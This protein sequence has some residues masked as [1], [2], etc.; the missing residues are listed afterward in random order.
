MICIGHSCPKSNFLLK[1]WGMGCSRSP[2]E[3]GKAERICRLPAEGLRR[4]RIF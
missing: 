2:D 3:I 4:C 1:A